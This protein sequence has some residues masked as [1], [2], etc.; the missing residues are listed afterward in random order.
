MIRNIYAIVVGAMLLP[1][2]L[3][4]QHLP[5]RN[6]PSELDLA[7]TYNAQRGNI[8]SGNNFWLQG[9]GAELT[10]TFYRGLGIAADVTGT[11]GGNIGS[12]G[13]GLTL[14]TATFGPTY[15]WT[16]PRHGK[17]QRQWKLFGESLLGIA[18]GLDSVF[19]NSA[20]VQSSDN[21][22]ALQ[23]GGGA[24]LNLSRHIAVRLFQADW[25][26]TQLPNAGTNTQNNL[27]LG[28]GIVF[29]LPR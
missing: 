14:V 4:A 7:V 17:S 19:P 5:A 23:M 24:D 9:G 25:V 22:L 26:R 1:S 3:W 10:A 15:T 16:L 12:S 13:V 27:Q 18:N 28:A 6:A 21:S 11:H 8:T 20:G 29:R 2:A